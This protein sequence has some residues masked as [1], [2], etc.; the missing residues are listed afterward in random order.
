MKTVLIT[1]VNGFLGS[2]L[3]KT[4]MTHGNQVIGVDLADESSVNISTYIKA[5]L[6]D[7]ENLSSI[8]HQLK[9]YDSIDCLINNAASKSNDPAS[10]FNEPVTYKPQTWRE[11][12]QIN[13]DAPYFLTMS[14]IEK[15]KN[16]SDASV[17]NISSIYGLIGPD[18][19]LYDGAQYMGHHINS[20]AVYS[21][22]KAG[23]IG[24][25]KWM[26]TTL[27]PKYG[28]RTNCVVPGGIDTGQNSKFKRNYSARVPLGRM[29][30]TNEIVSPILNLLSSDSKYINGHILVIDGGITAW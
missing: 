2:A 15:I 18:D 29:A 3:A 30:Q 17:I 7:H 22:S 14:L 27:T 26:A 28:I 11:V 8:S 25:T 23:L 10:F 9:E 16:S 6:A 5:D 19:R 4:L 13:L 1:G 12:M 20:P 21:A 24:L